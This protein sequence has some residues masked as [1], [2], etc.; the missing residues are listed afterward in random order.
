M[1]HAG[2]R[3][4]VADRISESALA[5]FREGGFDVTY[6]PGVQR[7]ALIKLLPDYE[8]L[9][10]RG[11]TRVD[12]ELIDAGTRLKVIARAGVGLDNVDVDY[13]VRRGIA[14]VNTPRAPTYSVGELT[15]G[16]M[17]SVARRIP[18]YDLLVKS[19]EWPKGRYVGLELHGKVLG[20]LGFGR[21]GRYVAKVAKCMGMKVLAHDIADVSSYA[22]ELGVELVDFEALLRSSDVISLHVPLT[23]LTYHMLNDEAL[24][25][26]GDGA[27]LI[28]TSRGEVVDSRALLAHIDRLWGV[29]L[30]VIE[31]EPPRTEYDLR[32]V[33]HEKVVVTPHIGSE[34]YEVQERIAQELVENVVEVLDRI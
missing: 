22:R 2:I 34:T 4:L 5:S 16:L 10:V 21:I 29:G 12:R 15:V 3:I 6:L 20:I 23:P 18:R 17:I 8:V 1:G 19:G 9:V 11:R 31:H 28:N 25:F 32:L 24:E 13:A 14:V 30:D 33:R 26:V 27:I 7:D